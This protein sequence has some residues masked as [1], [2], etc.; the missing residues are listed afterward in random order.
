MNQPLSQWAKALRCLARTP[1]DR[2][3]GQKKVVL[4]PRRWKLGR[5]PHS[6]GV[7]S[8]AFLWLLATAATLAQTASVPPPQYGAWRSCR[9]GGG[10]YAQNVV[11]CP[12]DP[13]RCY[14]YIDVGG[15][16]RSDDGGQ[17]WR[18]LHGSLPAQDGIYETRGLTVDPRNAEVILAAIGSQ[19]GSKPDGIFRSTDGG[20][21]WTKTLDAGFMGNGEDRWTGFLLTRDPK[22]PNTVTVA[23]ESTGVFRS[24]DNG[25]TWKPLGLTG[26]HPTDIRYDRTNPKRLW[27]CARPFNGW[28]GGKNV[29]L[30]A[31]F[32]RSDDG[33]AT[34]A[35]LADASPSEIIQD[36]ITANKLYG[37]VD[38]RVSVSDD[39]GATWRD[40]SDGLPAKL[41]DKG[42]TSESSFQAFA[43]GPNFLVTASTKGTFYTLKS[44]ATRWQKVDRQGLEE[45]YYGQP[46]FGAGQ[47]K[48]GSALASITVDP[49]DPAHWFFTDWFSIYQTRD[50]GQH[51]RLTMDGVE[52]T[53]LHCLTQDPADP[54]VVHLGM[55]DN[56]YFLS[57]NGGV[58]FNLAQGI[59]NNVKCVSLSPALPARVYAVGP[60]AWDWFANQVFVSLDRG[61][62]W[63]RSPMLGLPDMDKHHCNTIVADP[64]DPY[65]V[66]LCVSQTVGP[67]DGGVYKSVDGGKSWA[68]IGQGL[69]AGQSFFADS[70]WGIGRE[71]A[72]GSDGSLVALSRD[73]SQVFRYDAPHKLWAAVPMALKGQPYSVVAA[74]GA[75]YLGVEHDGIYKSRDDGQTWASVW[76]GSVHHV[77]VDAA[78]SE[79]LAAGT[80]DGVILSI[81]SGATWTALDKHLPYRLYNL[82]AFAGDRLLTGSA[83]SGAFWMPL[84]P[85]GD[86]PVAARPAAFA[87]VVGSPSALPPLH[88]GSMTEGTDTPTGWT[89]LWTA[90]G[91]LQIVRDT[92]DYKSA[93]ASLR[94]E[95]VGGPA[96][97]TV[98]Q[99]FGPAPD[100]FQVTGSVKSAGQFDESVFAVQEMDATGKQ[101]AWINLAN[102]AG[103]KTWQ[104][105]SGTVQL[106]P[107][108]ASWNLVLTLKGTGKVW[109]DDVQ[110]SSPPR[111]WK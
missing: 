31:A 33:G 108:A 6:E 69:P 21:T 68:W 40:A 65:T 39:G 1:T 94:L 45:N 4:S 87:A 16:F 30:T 34:W 92:S 49:R 84:A 15:M 61:Q 81:D 56:G 36:P 88:N 13:K 70:I 11:L 73:H 93:P 98:S 66:Y 102:A 53:V 101:V 105:F 35:K 28:L 89:N 63:T 22:D 20:E 91:K 100:A 106:P 90:S 83:G 71:L 17:T 46:W 97:G 12:S 14:A 78:H 59:S 43:A 18:M 107:E 62:T 74:P 8:I 38:Y 19:W 95:S 47:G 23:S 54:G 41:S 44:G 64:K 26:L 75:L 51:W 9:I 77:A 29:T 86:Q 10:G 85:A 96:Y 82:V 2:L 24:V 109:L 52:T 25:Q 110:F 57:E 111:V 7:H 72:V 103:A 80:D 3:R 79:R 32:Y 67:N 58:R 5:R 60:K 42:Y 104:A 99:P 37:I 27:L 48:F 50:S 55:A 76:T